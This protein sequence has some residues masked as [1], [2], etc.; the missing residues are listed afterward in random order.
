MTELRI[1]LFS[2]T[3]NQGH[4]SFAPN[5][6]QVI[7]LQSGMLSIDDQTIQADNGAYANSQSLITFATDAAPQVIRFEVTPNA[8]LTSDATPSLNNSKLLLSDTFTIDEDN[9]ILRLDRVTFPAN[10]VAYR[11]THSGAGI[12]YLLSGQLTVAA[13]EHTQLM[14]RGDAWFEDAYSPVKA[15]AAAEGITEFIR[16]M[17]LP[18]EFLGKPTIKRLNPEDA[19]KPTLQTNKRYFDLPIRF[20]QS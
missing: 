5:S 10:A 18:N 4:P 14:N 12:R 11:H 1:S 2:E 16:V 17:V 15:T 3:W 6:H 19:K 13:D 7:W 9:S 8:T 20:N